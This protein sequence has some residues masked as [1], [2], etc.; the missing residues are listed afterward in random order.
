MTISDS[1]R[2]S[3]IGEQL[4]TETVQRVGCKG[5][6]TTSDTPAYKTC[7]QVPIAGRHELAAAIEEMAKPEKMDQ[8]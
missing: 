1:P 2:G 3:S 5:C 7:V 4:G 8:P 6:G